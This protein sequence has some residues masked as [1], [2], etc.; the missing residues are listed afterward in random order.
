MTYLL[1]FVRRLASAA[2]QHRPVRV[3]EYARLNLP[4]F[5]GDAFIRVFVGDTSAQPAGDPELL[6]QM[7]DC[8]NTINLEF[9]LETAELRENALFK[10]DILIAVLTRF[11]EALAAEAALAEQ[12][13]DN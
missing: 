13:A 11:R 3:D 4:G 5:Y 1:Q 7:A 8:M 10:A 6:L 9:S 12:R 2:P